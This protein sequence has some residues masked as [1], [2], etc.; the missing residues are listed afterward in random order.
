MMKIFW[1]YKKKV[2]IIP[3]YE[4]QKVLILFASV[5]FR[6]GI[7]GLKDVS[8]GRGHGDVSICYN[9]QWY[10][11]ASVAED[12]IRPKNDRMHR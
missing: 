10:E 7:D 11:E 1:F 3:H 2:K 6:S 4:S 5:R 12:A 8:D 9:S